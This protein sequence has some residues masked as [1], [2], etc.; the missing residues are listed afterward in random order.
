MFKKFD[1]ITDENPLL[2]KES[3]NVATP[4]SDED[5]QLALDMLEYVKGS[6][7]DDIIEVFKTKEELMQRYNVSLYLRPKNMKSFYEKIGEVASLVTSVKE[8]KEKKEIKFLG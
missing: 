6:Q 2:R 3:S 5:K 8:H 7:D 1:I 4:I